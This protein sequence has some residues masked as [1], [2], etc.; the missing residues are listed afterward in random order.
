MNPGRKI[1]FDI[2]ALTVT[3][4]LFLFC[5]GTILS[6]DNREEGCMDLGMAEPGFYEKYT[7]CSFDFMLSF[8]HFSTYSLTN[9]EATDR[10]L[11]EQIQSSIRNIVATDNSQKGIHV[12]FNTKT[13]YEDFIRI[14]EI[15]GIEKAGCYIVD[16]YD[17]WIMT[18]KNK[19]LIERCPYRLTGNE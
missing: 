1:T 4:L 3:F 13:K 10:L 5:I 12:K 16:N 17:V 15:C 2:I 9:V 7:G 18:G 6:R 14:I 11:F 8:R 19:V